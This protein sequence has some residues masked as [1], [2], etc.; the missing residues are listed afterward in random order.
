MVIWDVCFMDAN[1]KDI[2]NYPCCEYLIYKNLLAS[3]NKRFRHYKELQKKK[4]KNRKALLGKI[5][6]TRNQC[7]KSVKIGSGKNKFYVGVIFK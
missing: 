7:T 2:W 3:W 5:M 6:L 1:N 4:K